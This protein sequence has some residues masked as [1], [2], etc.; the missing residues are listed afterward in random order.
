MATVTVNG[1]LV[2]PVTAL[3]ASGEIS[4]TLVDYADTP[5][6]GFDTTDQAEILSTC[7]VVPA[8]DGTWTVQLVPNASIQLT[9]GVAQTAWRV[10]ESGAGVTD[11]YW[12]VVPSGT[13][14][15]V[16][17]LR[18]TL[19]GPQPPN[20]TTNMA[21]SGALSVGGAFTLDGVTVAAPPSVTT[22]FLA[23][24]GAWRTPG[25]GP[26]SGT[27]GGDLGGTYPNP[28]LVSTTNVHTII[29]ARIPAALPPNGAA[30]GDLSGSY[31]APSVAKLAG[32]AVSGTPSAGN[33]L[34]A[35][36]P[37]AAAWTA[38]ASSRDPYTAKLGLLAQPFPVE[39]VDDVGLGLTAGFL[40]MMLVRPGAVTISN[41]GV[42]LGTAGV[43]PSGVNSMALFS[44]AGVQL[45][46][47]G[48]MSAA[49]SNAANNGT[50]VEAPVGAPYTTADA[51]NYYIGVLCQM[52]GGDPKIA[53]AFAGGV[54]HIPTIKGHR[55][56][57]TFGSQASMP[58]SVIIAN[59]NT[60]GAAYWLV[61]S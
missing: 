5:V 54:L 27:A 61:A 9:G 59:G 15:W 42:W 26:P 22:E 46:V 2:N 13:A 41:L 60:A 11:T 19:V 24:D 51:T 39:A 4:I 44:E 20:P 30:G 8:A 36:S 50:Y 33:V 58:A 47:T 53:G 28:T 35:T 29:D 45:A 34:V 38:P 7:T 25:G 23:G 32:V 17:D 21:I 40:V 16:G 57:I 31:P 3:P 55:D 43:T 14:Q 37:T 10:V 1:R 52:S 48:D 49:L 6:I 12:I 18:T 56:A